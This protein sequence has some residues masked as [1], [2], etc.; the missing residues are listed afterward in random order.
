MLPKV[1]IDGGAPGPL[2]TPSSIFLPPQGARPAMADMI[3]VTAIDLDGPRIAQSLAIAGTVDTVYAST[4]NLFVATSR[5]EAMFQSG[6]ALPPEPPLYLTDVHQI[7]LGSDAMAVAGSAS[8]EGYLDSNPDK[9]AFRLSDYQGRLRA[10]TSSTRAWGGAIQNRLTILEP[11]TLVPG[12]LKTVAYLPNRQRPESLGKPYE[13]VYGTRF[14]GDRLYAVTFRVV[15]PLYVVDLA[16]STDPR[17]AGALELPG[18]SEYLHPL[19]SGVLLGFG[20]DAKPAS[21]FGDGQGAWYQGLQLSLYDVRDVGKPREIQR[22][23]VGKRGS[24][25]ALLRDHHAFSA[26]MQP[27][28]TGSLA[29]PVHVAD[30]PTPL[31]GSGDS[32]FY[33]W[34]WSGLARF[35]L[36]GTS[37]ANA[38]LVHLPNLVAITTAPWTSP[39]F[40]DPATSS[41]RSVLF[42]NGTVYVGFGQFWRQDAAGHVSGPY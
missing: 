31:G 12:L 28:G 7:R 1:R 11:S 17:I 18:F 39:Y 21:G 5:Y 35:A 13:L 20:K 9:A 41:G 2:V 34:A 40:A 26:L 32:A 6:I 27:D 15:D 23:V 38:Q 4:S 8:I 29:I 3:L 10:V 36:T 42:R 22:V 33:P 16:D 19:P 25:S 24:D 14:V 30:G 37:A